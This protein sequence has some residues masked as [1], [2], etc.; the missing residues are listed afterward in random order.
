MATNLNG[1]YKPLTWRVE[2]I[3]PGTSPDDLK[4]YFYPEDR[5]YLK[6]KSLCPQVDTAEGEEDDLTATVYFNPPEVGRVPRLATDN[7]LVDKDFFGFT[8]LYFPPKEK[9]PIT[10]E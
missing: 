5:D 4:S 6:V 8:P 10:A 3:P 2:H 1:S 7:I 9:G